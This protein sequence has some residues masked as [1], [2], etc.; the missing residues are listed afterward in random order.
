MKKVRDEDWIEVGGEG[1]W[2]EYKNTKTGES[3]IK[4][5]GKISEM[6]DVLIPECDCYYELVTPNG[7]AV[8]C[9]KCGRGKNIVWGIEI[10]RDGTI[11]K[12]I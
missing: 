8:Q 3:S 7:S 9:Q 5:F 10:L 2:K 1:V 4:S 12:K 11:I 6:K